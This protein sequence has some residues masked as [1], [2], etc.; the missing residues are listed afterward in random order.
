MASLG[1]VFYVFA[2]ALLLFV[3]FTFLFI[4][5]TVASFR[6]GVENSNRD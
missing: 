1:P 6:D 2:A 3:F 5:R 4:R